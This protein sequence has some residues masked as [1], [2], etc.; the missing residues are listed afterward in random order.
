MYKYI[1]VYTIQYLV[2]IILQYIITRAVQHEKIN[3]QHNLAK[4]II[5][6][7]DI[8]FN[9]TILL[10]GNAFC[11]AYLSLNFKIVFNIFILNN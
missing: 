8:F 1:L 3:G 7:Y 4:L 11:Q 5:E 10:K 6:L 9:R 2:Y